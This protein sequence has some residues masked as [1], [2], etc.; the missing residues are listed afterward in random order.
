MVRFT[1]RKMPVFMVQKL[2]FPYPAAITE[3]LK[4]AH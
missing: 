1:L 2:N 4:I 3:N